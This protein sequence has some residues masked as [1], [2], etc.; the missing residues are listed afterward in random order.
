MSDFFVIIFWIMIGISL[1][2]AP[3]ES[4]FFITS[5][6]KMGKNEGLRKALFFLFITSLLTIF[7][8]TLISY[9]VLTKYSM[10]NNLWAIIPILILMVGIIFFISTNKL[11]KSLKII[12]EKKQ[13][14]L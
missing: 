7:D 5:L 2:I 8:A 9:F 3:I 4:I 1:T 14:N 6:V 12:L 13:K 10:A 11:I